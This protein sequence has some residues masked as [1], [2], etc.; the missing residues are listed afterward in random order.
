MMRAS[1][2]TPLALAC[3]SFVWAPAMGQN[4]LAVPMDIVRISN[5]E[6]SAASPG[7]VTLFRVYPQYTLEAIH[8]SSRTEVSF[9]GS[10]ERSSNTLLSANRTFP[11]VRL[12]WEGSSPVAVIGLRGSLE[13]SS[14]RETEFAEFG[15]V[16]RDSKARTGTIAGSWTRNLALGSDLELSASHLRVT[17][18]TPLLVDYSE[19]LGSVVYRFES[20]ANSR[21]SLIGSASR[22]NPHGVGESTS[23][24]ELRMGYE[25]D[26][27]ENVTLFAAAGVVRTSAPNRKTHPVGDLRLAYSGERIAYS[28]SWARDVSSG[29]S[30][31]GYTRS[32]SAEASM[33]YPFTTNTS[34]SLGVGLAQSR[35]ADRD[36]GATSYMRIR[37]ELTR[38]WALTMGLEHRRAMPFGAPSARGNSVSVGLVYTHPDF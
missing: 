2:F 8:G 18:D 38:F 10:I 17:Y 9:G 27:S 22:L 26:I 12:L 21:Y 14:T 33:S 4:T 29:S 16:I 28:I 24:S 23:R 32:D 7:S 30:V 37:S 34:L 15:R 25:A 13:E 20:S 3:Q 1:F 35:E 36:A 31:G 19:T 5:P 11:N 6:L